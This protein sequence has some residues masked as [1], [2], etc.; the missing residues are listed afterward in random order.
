MKKSA[1]SVQRLAFSFLLITLLSSCASPSPTAPVFP[2]F[3]LITQ[4]PNASPTPTPFQPSG[5]VNTPLATFTQAPPASATATI[6]QTPPPTNTAP[7]SPP[8]S[9]SVP[10][11][12]PPPVNSSRT[13][14][15][16]YST[17]DFAG[18]TLTTD[19]TVRYYNNTGVSLSE[20]VFSVQPN[21]YGN[22]FILNSI[23]QDG[24]ALTS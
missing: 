24:T 7:P 21:R 13:N 19:Q 6:T 9:D 2:T 12:L 4:D 5:E 20:I 8:T 16:L 18:K 14:Y 23:S 10:P 22:A 3:I 17:L 15:I 1:F 11:I